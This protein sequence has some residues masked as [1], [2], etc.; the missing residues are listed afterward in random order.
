MIE[1]AGV[2]QE[3]VSLEGTN[4]NGSADRSLVEQLN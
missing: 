1:E 3:E 4:E 2:V